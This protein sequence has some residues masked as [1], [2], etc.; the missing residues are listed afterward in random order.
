[1]SKRKSS[2]IIVAKRSACAT[3]IITRL[4]VINKSRLSS[5]RQ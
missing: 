1:M 4:A 5:S 2:R 3:S